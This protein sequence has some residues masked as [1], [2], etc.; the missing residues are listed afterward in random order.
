MIWNCYH[1]N[2]KFYKESSHFPKFIFSQNYK[3]KNVM[4]LD[5]YKHLL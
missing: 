5:N 4:Y 2:T 1:F 3:Q